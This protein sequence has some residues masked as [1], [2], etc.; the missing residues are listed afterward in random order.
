[1]RQK[2]LQVEGVP[3]NRNLR[4]TLTF[5]CGMWRHSYVVEGANGAMEFTVSQLMLSS[6]DKNKREWSAGLEAHYAYPQEGKPPDHAF[7]QAISFRPCWHDGTS[8]YAQER[9]LPQWIEC[10]EDP[11]YVFQMLEREYQARFDSV[12]IG[13]IAPVTPVS[14]VGQ[15]TEEKK[16]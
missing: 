4:Y 5:F 1:M 12:G 3:R 14:V 13:A 15:T 6:S 16:P 2:Y 8:L 9:L 11:V 10:G 7:C